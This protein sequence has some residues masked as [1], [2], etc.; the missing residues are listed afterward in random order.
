MYKS[1]IELIYQGMEY[2]IEKD[3]LKAVH[4][5]NINVDKQELIRA[6]QYDRNQY[7]KGYSDA[8]AKQKW[9]PVSEGLTESGKHVLVA[10][11][12]HSGGCVYGRYVCDGYYAAPKSLTGGCSDDCAT[13]YDEEDDEYYLLE[14]WY[15]VI[16][17]WDDY[18]SIVIHSFVTHWM[19]LPEPPKEGADN[20]KT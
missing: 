18:N 15:E 6:L 17:N 4:K 1:P 9:I 19:P 3:I 13:E 2:E 16:K 14:G 12:I 20:G 11:E 10:C 7:E 8:M 5:Q